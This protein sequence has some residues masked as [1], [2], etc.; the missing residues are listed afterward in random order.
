MKNNLLYTTLIAGSMLLSSCGEDLLNLQPEQSL[1]ND[2]VF[3]GPA[4]ATGAM[5]G[6]YSL[7]Q[8]FDVFGSLPAII[9][10]FQAD[11]VDF[12]GSFPTLQEIRLFS[13]AADNGS[14]STM[15]YQHYRVINAANNVIARVN[16]VPGLSDALKAQFVAEARFMRALMHFQL[17]NNYAQPANIGGD[18]APGVPIVTEPF[19]GTV[20][21]PARATVGEVHAFIR[22]ELAAIVGA[23]PASYAT[24]A[25]TRGRATSGA[26]NAL[27]AR[28]HLYRGE[29]ADAA[30][31]ANAVL[32]SPLYAL[33]DDYT[34]WSQ[35][36]PEYVFAIQNLA[37][38]NGRTG[39]GGWAAYYNPAERNSRGDCPF[40]NYLINAYN[41]EAG[42]RRFTQLT[43]VG[44]NGRTYTTKFNDPFNNTDDAPVIRTTEMALTRAEAL[45]R[46]TNT[47]NVEALT[48]LNNLR[49]RAGLPAFV[50][51]DAT[52]L[53]NQILI[54]RR[55]ELA[56][57]GHRRMD[58]LRNGE[59][60]RPVGD[61]QRAAS[62]PGQDRTI[63]PIP[64]RE[65]D[66]N[67]NLT[68]NPGY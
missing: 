22:T 23:L 8:Q 48:I 67:P 19:E 37:I 46:S 62:A 58:L 16:D 13:T 11:N 56:F 39:S 12:I 54:E 20:E 51:I 64:Q 33:A 26:A 38:D 47:V 60:L 65:R 49:A 44:A 57:E 30:T 42:D 6:V 17:V 18:G 32:S 66:L 59:H 31:A 25:F 5:L 2:V 34:F 4:E 63:M 9:A 41:E 35:N 21:L 7:S 3:S 24:A 28:L 53:L 14:L 61:A 52:S 10:D 45:V 43:Q 68:Q 1:S 29:W 36:G 50:A 15:W 55:K 40:S 27:L